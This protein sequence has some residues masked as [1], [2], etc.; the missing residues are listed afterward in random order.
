ME[1]IIIKIKTKMA[2]KIRIVEE[3][4]INIYEYRKRNDG[5][6]PKYATISYDSFREL[7]TV[8]LQ[9]YGD[10]RRLRFMNVIILKSQDL[11]TE[12]IVL[13]EEKMK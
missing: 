5:F 4:E 9:S 11:E 3:L 1:H 8:R 2:N 6:Y 12:E 7:E 10:R 13:S